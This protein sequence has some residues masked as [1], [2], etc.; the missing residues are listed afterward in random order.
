MSHYNAHSFH[1][2]KWSKSEAEKLTQGLK[3]LVQEA[4]SLTPNALFDFSFH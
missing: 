3:D 4:G 1:C 2:Y